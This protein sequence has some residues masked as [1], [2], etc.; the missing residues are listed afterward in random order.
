MKD[1]YVKITL[2]AICWVTFALP[3][4]LLA[5]ASGTISGYV[6]DKETSRE[7]PGASLVVEGTN[8][9][10]MADKY[11]FYVIYNVPVGRHTIRASMIGYVPMKITDVE[12]KTD[13]NTV[14]DFDLQSRVLELGEEIVVT[15]PRV[16]ILRDVLAS[17][18][19]LGQET[20]NSSFPA[21]NF[22]DFLPMIPGYV[23][24][25][26]RA[27]RNSGVQYLIDG[28]PAS[29]AWTRTMAFSLPVSA[30]TEMVVQTGG[31]SAEYGNL[32]SGLVN[33]ITKDGRNNLGLSFKLASDFLSRY[34]EVY[35]NAQRAEL[36]LGGPLK[37]GFGGPTLDANYF[38]SGK[39]EYTDT[40]H[41]EVLRSSFHAPILQNYDWNAKLMF[42]LSQNLFL[43]GQLLSSRWDWRQYDPHWQERSSAL[44]DRLDDNNRVSLSL[45]HTLSAKTYYQ[46]EV[47]HSDFDRRVDGHVPEGAEDNYSVPAPENLGSK[48]PWTPEP[49]QEDLRERQWLGRA[50]LVRHFNSVHQLKVGVEGSYWDLAWQRDRYLLWADG[51]SRKGDYVYSRYTDAFEENPF[52]FVGYAHHKIELKD[53]LATFGLRYEVFSPNR[54]ATDLNQRIQAGDLAAIPLPQDVL[55]VTSAPEMRTPLLPA[56]D[57]SAV[58]QPRVFHHTFAPRLS[59]AIPIGNI[60]HLSISYGH[61]YELP[62]FYHLYVNEDGDRSAYWTIYG[63]PALKPVQARAWEATYRRA[64]TEQTVFTLTGFWRKYSN[65]VGMKRYPLAQPTQPGYPPSVFQYENNVEATSGG[66]E[67]SYRRQFGRAFS[68]AVA[69]TYL[70]GSGTASWPESKLLG[71][72]RGELELN[73]NYLFPL[74]WD[75]RHTIA[76]FFN[77]QSAKGHLL[78]AF[79][80]IYGPAKAGDWFA[81]DEVE[82]GWRQFLSIKAAAP[83]YFAGLRLQPFLEGRNLLNVKYAYPDQSAIGSTQPP[84]LLEDNLGRRIIVGISFN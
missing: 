18:H 64:I 7:L 75:Q 22:Y 5:G 24:N 11:G 13:L 8:F 26:F 84:A 6:I 46:L 35:E 72:S 1:S 77:W 36:A 17:A 31:F 47:S 43:R 53:F 38:I 71:L 67:L 55:Q 10:A 3:A 4:M 49:W 15:A 19:Y 40:P 28:L 33:L 74:A 63:N 20:I 81:G 48:W 9:G 65:L 21:Q 83:L 2:A 78:S 34:D 27:S 52:Y 30:I 66:L 14:A 51:D 42:R 23:N 56:S 80:Q 41:R 61:F 16:Q 76:L 37:L 70:H 68:G 44:P 73:D 79:S 29:D 62:S 12:V 25:H 54:A 58:P 69:Y 60:E 32:T 45:T 50:N 82:L 57:S 59:F 39:V